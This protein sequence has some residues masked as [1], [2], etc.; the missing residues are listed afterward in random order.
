M[1]EQI[2][3]RPSEL[4]VIKR[5]AAAVVRAA[6]R[7]GLKNGVVRSTGAAEV[8]IDAL[9]DAV[10]EQLARKETAWALAVIAGVQMAP[11]LVKEVP[12][13]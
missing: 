13:G 6:V 9:E 8:L 11:D 3:D 7:A 5:S 2:L 10:C 12:R 1:A 4:E